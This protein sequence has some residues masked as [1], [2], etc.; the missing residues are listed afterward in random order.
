MI[1]KH[2]DGFVIYPSKYTY[3]DI[4]ASPYK[5]GQGDILEELSQLATKYDMDLVVYLSPWDANH[6]KYHV[7]TEGKYNEYYLNQLKEILGNDKYGNNGKFKQV[8][9]E[10]VVMAPKRLP[11]LMISGLNI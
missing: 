9:M 7:D 1:T 10:Y 8:W 2:H 5:N 4:G 11:I 6:Q 3:H